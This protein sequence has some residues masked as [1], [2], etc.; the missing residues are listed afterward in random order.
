MQKAVQSARRAYDLY[1]AGQNVEIWESTT[2]HGYQQDKR[3][4]MYD[5]VERHFLHGANPDSEESL[6]LLEP[7]HRLDCGMPEDNKTFASIYSEWLQRPTPVPELPDNAQAARRTQEK[8]EKEVR[9][10]L[11]LREELAPPHMRVQM[12]SSRENVLLRQLIIEPE[13]GIRLPAFEIQP[14]TASTGIVILPGKSEQ[15]A[16]AIAAMLS[17]GLT[18]LLV[19]P[20]GTGEI[21]GGGRRTD[22][23]AWF[24]GRSWTGMWTADLIAVTSALSAERPGQH[25]GL[26][27]TGQF[28]KSALFASA[29]CSRISASAVYLEQPTYRDGIATE[30]LSD[31]PRILALTDLPMVA[32]LSAPR[33]CRIEF[34]PEVEGRFRQAYQ[35]T[36]KFS[37]GGF[38]TA[39]LE[40][41][42]AAAPD[43]KNLALWFAGIL[44]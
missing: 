38:G 21:D 27:G 32:A 11:G 20:R 22:N 14:R 4:R 43:W 16:E 6:F 18:V 44:R 23:W 31:V 29:L 5:F 15:P 28:A 33:P 42:P 37:E 12:K 2:A 36:N 17:E 10:L 26:I 41:R 13:D 39:N 25:I 7:Q 40:L 35:W 8:L 19:D 1:D 9:E 24:M 3:E 34:S 30:K